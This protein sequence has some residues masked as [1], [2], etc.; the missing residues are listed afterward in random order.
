MTNAFNSMS[1]SII[2]QKICTTNGYIIQLIPFVHS[3]YVFKFPLFYGH[4]NWE[5]DVIITPFAM[6]TCQGDSLGGPLFIL[7][8]FKALCS[9]FNHF[10]FCLFPSIANDIHIID[11]FQLYHLHLSIFRSNFVR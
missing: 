5:C 8:H 2:F 9:T 6:G 1:R 4:C 3:F 10:P 7:D 11:P